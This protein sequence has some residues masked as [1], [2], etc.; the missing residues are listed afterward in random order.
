MLWYVRVHYVLTKSPCVGNVKDEG[1][2]RVVFE[3]CQWMGTDLVRGDGKV[4]RKLLQ[5]SKNMW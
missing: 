5:S 4:A 1:S 2:I 3:C